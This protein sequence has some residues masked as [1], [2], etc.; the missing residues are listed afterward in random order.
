MPLYEYQCRDCNGEAELLIQN[1]QQPVCPKCGSQ[2]LTRL[3]SVVA[4]PTREPGRSGG[5]E[6]ST[7]PCGTHCGCHPRV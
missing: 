7:G 2:R 1:S 6:R 3:L 5:A 4:S